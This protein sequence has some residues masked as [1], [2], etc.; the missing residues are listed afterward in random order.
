[1]VCRSKRVGCKTLLVSTLPCLGL[2]KLNFD[3]CALGNRDQ[4]ETR[5]VIRDHHSGVFDIVFSLFDHPLYF[6]R[7]FHPS[8]LLKIHIRK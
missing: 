6:G 4:L 5:G 8:F 2:I 1:M 3:G 7:T